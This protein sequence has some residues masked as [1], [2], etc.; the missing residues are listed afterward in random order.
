MKAGDAGASE[1]TRTLGLLLI[2]GF[3]LMSYASIIEPFRAAN[4]LAGR[5]L[6]RWLH[7]A[8]DGPAARASNGAAILVDR[9]VG[10]SFECDVLF[11]F[12]GGDP[13]AV[14]DGRVFEL[15]RR[16]ARAGAAIAGVSGG[17]YLLAKAGLL[18]GHR[19]TI[20]WEHA[21]AFREDFPLIE[22]ASGLYAIDRRR[23]TCAGGV[24]GLDLAI[25]LIE[26][27]HGHA[28][29]ARVGE[30]FIRTESRPAERPQRPS[31]RER[32]GVRHDALVKVLA[33][34]EASVE[35]PK[36]RA[37]LARAAGVSLRQLERLFHAELGSTIA[38]A[39]LR[40]RLAQAER[41]LRTT[42]LS[43]AEVASA[44]GFSSPSHFARVFRKAFGHPPARRGGR[45]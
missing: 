2:D 39:Y 31:V 10:D 36:S 8:A 24:A 29:A 16:Q 14:D 42:G 20:H 22:L 19:A 34:M 45:P 7:V 9:Q 4:T 27:D 32:Y 25:D 18:A 28:L 21:E 5:P 11:V 13:R 33:A 38:R 3:A 35:E 6:Y 17:P 40:I 15:L 1:E 26:R 41:T 37:A 43:V 44:C 12:A 30:W 23:M